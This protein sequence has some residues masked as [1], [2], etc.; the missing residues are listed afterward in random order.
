MFFSMF[1]TCFSM[2]F[3]HRFNAV[4]IPLE[5]EMPPFFGRECRPFPKKQ[6]YQSFPTGFVCIILFTNKGIIFY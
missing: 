1:S 2:L 6:P 5:K 3:K 4:L